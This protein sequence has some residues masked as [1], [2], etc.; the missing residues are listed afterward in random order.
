MKQRPAVKLNVEPATARK[1]WLE[2][3]GGRKREAKLRPIRFFNY[4]TPQQQQQR[5]PDGVRGDRPHDHLP[6]MIPYLEAVYGVPTGTN[7]LKTTYQHHNNVEGYNRSIRRFL[8]SALI[9]PKLSGNF[10][11]LS[12]S[13]RQKL[14]KKS[15]K[16]IRV[17]DV[18]II[19]NRRRKLSE[20]I[21]SQKMGQQ[22]PLNPYPFC[23][24]D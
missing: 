12:K 9:T 2:T 5:L 1:R 18:I 3:I 24:V 19:G 23:T 11:F 6:W 15:C 22:R 14:Y 13:L 4:P 20:E 8:N 21:H 10:P 7:Q 16:L 17:E